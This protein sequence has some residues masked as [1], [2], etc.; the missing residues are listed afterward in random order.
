MEGSNNS[1]SAQV[2]IYLQL[3][4]FMLM[5]GMNAIMWTVFVKALRH[6]K[7]SLEATV[8]NTAANFF[9]SV[10]HRLCISFQFF[11]IPGMTCMAQLKF[12]LKYSNV[13]FN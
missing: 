10:I 1:V 6:C 11:V 8:T 3:F 9:F 5:I 7:T 13:C 12:R 2:A 4:A